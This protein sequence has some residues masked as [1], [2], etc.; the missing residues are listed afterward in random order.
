MTDR[1]YTPSNGTEGEIFF[2]NWCRH[3]ARDAAMNSGADYDECDDNEIC[4]IIGILFVKQV[5][6]WVEDDKG[7]R[8]TAFIPVGD[9]VPRV[10]P[11][12]LEAAGQCRL[13]E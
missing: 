10:S 2:E 5:P 6:E 13:I 4:P 1:P 12:E 8:C 11:K 7:P 3:C 9:T